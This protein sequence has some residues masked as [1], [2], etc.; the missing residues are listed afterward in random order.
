MQPP[1]A[2]IPVMMPATPYLPPQ[3]AGGYYPPQTA[4]MPP[5]TAGS[6]YHP[7]DGVHLDFKDEAKLDFKMVTPAPP[8]PKPERPASK[9]KPKTPSKKTPAGKPDMTM[10]SPLDARPS[11]TASAVKK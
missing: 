3:T 1:G 8:E 4:G 10:E 7:D 5:G 2:Q 11:S 6:V 9:Q